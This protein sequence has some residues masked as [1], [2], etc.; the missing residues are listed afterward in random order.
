MKRIRRFFRKRA[1]KRKARARRS[2]VT[3]IE[4]WV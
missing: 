1:L 3:V 2:T 4:E